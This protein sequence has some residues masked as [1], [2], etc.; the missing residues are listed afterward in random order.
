[1]L[2]NNKATDALNHVITILHS[3]QNF[4]V[5]FERLKDEYPQL[6]DFGIIYK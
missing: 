1:V 4:V 2:G 5:G 3:M 6:P